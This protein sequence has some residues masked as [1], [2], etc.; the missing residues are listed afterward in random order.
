MALRNDCSI[1]DVAV[2]E[3]FPSNPPPLIAKKAADALQ[4]QL[5]NAF[6]EA[7]YEGM[8]PM[9]AL[10]V[11]ISWVSFE[12]RRSRPENPAAS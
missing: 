3:L 5:T 11:I 7:L 9:D 4:S 10:S 8:Q 12:I 1:L 2:E 6:E